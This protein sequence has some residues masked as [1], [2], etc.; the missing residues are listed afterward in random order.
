[1][2]ND[3][4]AAAIP[5]RVRTQEEMLPVRL[6]GTVLMGGGESSAELAGK[7]KS[8][9]RVLASTDKIFA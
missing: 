8:E 9:G 6:A 4:V 1:M 5:T 2:L 7:K 3:Q